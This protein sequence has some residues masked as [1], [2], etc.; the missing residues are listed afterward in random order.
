MLKTE[1]WVD[2]DLRDRLMANLALRNSIF[3]ALIAEGWQPCFPFIDGTKH[4]QKRSTSRHHCQENGF[5]PCLN[6]VWHQFGN[7]E[8]FTIDITAKPAQG[9][10]MEL[11]SYSI[12]LDELP[13]VKDAEV[14]RLVRCWDAANEVPPC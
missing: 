11:K 13:L 6:L 4:F 8:S 5:P 9:C 1:Q 2:P 12:G 7:I 10:W 14:A 3:D